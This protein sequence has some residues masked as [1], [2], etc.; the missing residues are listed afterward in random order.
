MITRLAVYAATNATATAEK[1]HKPNKFFVGDWN[2]FWWGTIAFL[3]VVGLFAWKGLPA[4]KA[5]YAKRTQRISDEIASAEAKKAAA[6]KELAA[7]R[8]SLG[9]AG[10][11]S[12]RIVADAR[13]TAAQIKADLIARAESDAAEQKQRAKI[14]IEASKGQ[15]LADL[16]AEISRLTV[17]ATEEIVQ[18][19]LTEKT[20]VD[21]VEQYIRA[22]EGSR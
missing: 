2:E 17:A 20:K 3:I 16:K 1:V 21:L 4:I 5:A 22:L 12:K 6:D 7:L 8:A 18:S 19:A 10:E 9:D 15:S 13:Q 11:E 14:E